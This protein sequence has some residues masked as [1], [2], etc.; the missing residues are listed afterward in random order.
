MIPKYQQIKTGRD[1]VPTVK[2]L[3]K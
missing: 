3:W 2:N 1:N